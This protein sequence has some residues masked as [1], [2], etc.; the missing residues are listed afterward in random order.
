MPEIRYCS[1]SLEFCVIWVGTGIG[2]F[3]GWGFLCLI[4]FE[5]VW[6]P[7]VIKGGRGGLWLCVRPTVPRPV[8]TRDFD[9]SSVPLS[10]PQQSQRPVRSAE[11]GM[12]NSF[13]HGPSS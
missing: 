7:F 13:A 9:F 11:C 12:R 1:N 6:R 10:V 2:Q 4:K 3:S 8:N 5:Y